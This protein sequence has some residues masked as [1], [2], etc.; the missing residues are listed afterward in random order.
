M[1]ENYNER[2]SRHFPLKSIG[3]KGQERLAKSR[4]LIAGM[5]GLGTMSS[6]LLASV[7]VG[8]LRIVDYDVIEMSNLPRQKLYDESEINEAKVE[9]ASK[10]LKVRNPY[11]IID[12]HNTRVDALSSI[13]LLED[14]DIVVDGL[15]KFSSR[16]ALFQVARSMKI[17]YV[18]CGAVG[19]AANIMVFD[20]SDGNPCLICIV[21]EIGDDNDQSCEKLGVHPSILSIAASIQASEVINYVTKNDYSNLND[22]MLIISLT[23]LSFDKIKIEMNI[24]CRVCNKHENDDLDHGKKGETKKGMRYIKDYGEILVTSLCG[25]DT[26]I[27][28]PTWSI[29][30]D[31]ESVKKIITKTFQVQKDGKK[32]ISFE[33]DNVKIS[34]LDTGIMTLRN[35]GSTNK[36]LEKFKEI[37]TTIN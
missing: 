3:K 5:G 2:Y 8:Y 9:V 35:S 11:I 24:N 33:L 12:E 26:K 15:D 32:F 20:H 21:G 14:I 27:L 1:M 37:I 23:D 29:D 34:L 6:E 19:E 30:W 7:G 10:K 13:A 28:D 18:F 17:P 4:I 36:A 22:E 31:F 25:R 16:K